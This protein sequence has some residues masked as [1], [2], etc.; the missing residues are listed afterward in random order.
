[1]PEPTADPLALEAL[2]LRYA[3]GRLSAVAAAAF[4]ARLAHDQA[5]RDALAEAVQLSAA[6]L[7]QDPPAPD[8]SFRAL[9]RDRLR[10]GPRW[11][12]RRA[13][14]GHPLAWAGLGAG[15]VAA[16]TVI[17]L[18]LAPDRPAEPVRVAAVAPPPAL[19]APEATP[20]PPEPP[21]PVVTVAPRPVASTVARSAEPDPPA[22]PSAAEIWAD[23]STP[24]HLEKAHGDDARL[25]QLLRDLHPARPTTGLDPDAP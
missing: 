9:I 2:A 21:A 24:A 22:A 10:R 4:E 23:L 5:A 14:R 16:A 8:R 6:A 1:M 3:A 20:A 13:Y 7:G 17:G 11:L 15:T 18:E 19:P 25:R 12:A